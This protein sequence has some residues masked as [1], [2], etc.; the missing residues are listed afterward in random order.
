MDVHA[1]A[2]LSLCIQWRV[3][4]AANS[5]LV[6][7]NVY[8]LRCTMHCQMMII[9]LR[10]FSIESDILQCPDALFQSCKLHD[11]W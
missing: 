6:M 4:S 7:L 8:H 3:L 9:N 11:E 5:V 2:C 10:D 1:K